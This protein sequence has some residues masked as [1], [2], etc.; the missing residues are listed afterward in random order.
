MLSIH[1][2]LGLPSGL[3]PSGFPTNN[4][5]TFLFS[6]IRACDY[7]AVTQTRDNLQPWIMRCQ[8]FALCGGYHRKGSAANRRLH[9]SLSRHLAFSC[10]YENLL[11]IINFCLRPRS[12]ASISNSLASFHTYLLNWRQAISTGRAQDRQRDR[13]FLLSGRGLI[14]S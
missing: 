13:H 4:L 5:Y 11:H 9:C 8:F 2:R 14:D 1:L 3:F 12:R 6:P 7:I 10:K